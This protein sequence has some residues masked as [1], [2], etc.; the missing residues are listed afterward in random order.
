MENFDSIKCEQEQ[1]Q[2]LII[3]LINLSENN[4]EPE[5]NMDRWDPEEPEEID[6]LEDEL[7]FAESDD[8][9]GQW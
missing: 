3:T 9:N 7:E 4:S 6:P 2:K 8:E 5:L 1:K